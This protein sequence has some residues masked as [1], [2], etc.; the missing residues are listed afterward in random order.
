MC[1]VR[2]RPIP[3]H[4]QFRF[5]KIALALSSSS[6][7]SLSSSSIFLNQILP[8]IF[9]QFVIVP[10]FAANLRRTLLENLF[11]S[12]LRLIMDLCGSTLTKFKNAK[13]SKTTQIPRAATLSD[14]LRTTCRL[15]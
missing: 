8:F 13:T 14:A 7:K 9:I 4:C 10:F 11:M 3:R 12:T 2:I 15:P 6:I 5:E 1:C